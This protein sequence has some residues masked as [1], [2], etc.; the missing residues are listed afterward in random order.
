V[1]HRTGRV[2]LSLVQPAAAADGHVDAIL[3]IQWLERRT[4]PGIVRSGANG[5]RA[6][7]RA[8]GGA[9]EVRMFEQVGAQGAKCL[10]AVTDRRLPCLLQ[11]A[12]RDAEWGL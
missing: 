6:P 12:E 4:P 7:L 1:R 2:L 10:A 5:R 8:V 9:D 11:F 3:R